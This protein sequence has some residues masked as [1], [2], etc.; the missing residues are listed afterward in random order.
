MWFVAINISGVS[1]K[2]PII[3]LFKHQVCLQG[4]LW[5]FKLLHS[6]AARRVHTMKSVS[7]SIQ[8]G[9]LDKGLSGPGEMKRNFDHG[10]KTLPLL[11]ADKRDC[12]FRRQNQNPS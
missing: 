9:R 1:T 10:A 2:L 8:R 12:V 7:Q 6:G 4:Q 11:N 3:A 5:R